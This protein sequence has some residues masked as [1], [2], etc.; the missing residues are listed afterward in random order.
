MQVEIKDT[1][2][3]NC[4]WWASRDAQFRNS[5]NKTQWDESVKLK[6]ERIKLVLEHLYWGRVFEA[7][8]KR[9]VAIK[10]DRAQVKNSERLK[11]FEAEWSK[12]G[13]VKTI[14]PQG[15]LYRIA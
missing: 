11:E 7:Y 13:I 4:K 2:P 5:C 8:G 15:V 10:I 12:A 1:Q 9:Q 14:T 3:A 6:V